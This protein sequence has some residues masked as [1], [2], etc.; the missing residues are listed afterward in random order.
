L[1]LG[2]INVTN[3]DA[4]A[5]S[6]TLTWIKPASRSYPPYTYGLANTLQLQGG[7]WTNPPPKTPAIALTNGQLVI[8]NANLLLTYDIAVSNND[9]LLKLA[10]S[11]SSNS[12]TGSISP[13]TGL[14]TVTFG[15]GSGK[16]TTQGL[17][18]ILQSQTNGGGFFPGTTNAGLILLSP[19]Q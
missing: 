17:G 13:K 12:L 14:L 9:T 2:W 7:L 4:A 11:P 5:P 3:L 6:N 19:A 10:A 8:S 15:N 1:L 18:A 16:A